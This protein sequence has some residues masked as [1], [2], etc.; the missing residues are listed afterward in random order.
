MNSETINNL[1]RSEM[2]TLN[3]ST[4]HMPSSEPSFGTHSAHSFLYGYFMYVCFDPYED[5]SNEP[6]WITKV[7]SYAHKN[8]F[9]MIVFDADGPTIPSLKTFDWDSDVHATACLP[10]VHLRA[11]VEQDSEVS[12]DDFSKAF[13]KVAGIARE[14]LDNPIED[15]EARRRDWEERTQAIILSI[16]KGANVFELEDYIQYLEH[17]FYFLELTKEEKSNLSLE[18]A[19]Y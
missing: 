3:I 16:D 12:D 7:L 9:D 15:K 8:S 4:A 13:S 2:K 14:R 10:D 18:L 19:A 5:H 11:R 1:C 6:D 17:S